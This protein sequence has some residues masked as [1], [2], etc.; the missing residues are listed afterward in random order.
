MNGLQL[1]GGESL[2]AGYLLALAKTAGFVAVAPPF[3]SRGIAAQARVG[4]AL[5]FAI[6]LSAITAPRAPALTSSGFFGQVLLQLVFGA[7]LGAFVLLAV[8]VIQTV[9]D[10]V[11]VVGG[12]SLSVAMDPLLLVQSSVMGRLHQ[13]IAVTLLF[14]GDGHLM[15]LQGLIR[16][17]QLMPVAHPDWN[18]FARAI[19][20]DFSAVMLG[21]VQIAAPII[22]AM[23]IADVTLGLLT[24]AAPALNAFSLAFPLKILLSLLLIGLVV[25]QLPDALHQVVTRAVR[26]IVQASGGG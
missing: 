10:I 25:V 6:P 22:G 19:A 15:I 26:T 11:D 2:L 8:A 1:S 18:G 13:L 24:K 17:T 3:S 14:A 16:S 12:F 9:G 7:A 5:A 20:G 23:L 21:A 4:M